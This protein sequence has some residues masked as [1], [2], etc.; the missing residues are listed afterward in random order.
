MY[1]QKLG[2]SHG[3]SRSAAALGPLTFP[4]RP[5]GCRPLRGSP[6]PAR[7]QT[8]RELGHR[9]SR[10]RPHKMR[11]SGPLSAGTQ[12]FRH[13][14]R[15]PGPMTMMIQSSKIWRHRRRLLAWLQLLRRTIKEGLGR[16]F[17]V[18]SP[19]PRRRGPRRSG[20]GGMVAGGGMM[21]QAC[22]GPGLMA[23]GM[24]GGELQVPRGPQHS[25]RVTR[26]P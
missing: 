26:L 3:R 12:I 2:S 1:C 11:G 16:R 10:R 14:R 13:R 23:V 9:S 20:V 17:R 4:R 18:R 19:R 6:L 8:F 5:L 22:G 25:V 24:P 21:G 7:T 15:R